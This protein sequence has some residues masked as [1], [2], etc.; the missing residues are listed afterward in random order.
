LGQEAV[1]DTK[2]GV[3]GAGAMGGGIA[4][5]AIRAGFETV[6][7]DVAE[8]A[9]ADARDRIQR[10]L[11]RAA[12][13]SAERQAPALD[14]ST[15]MARLLTTATRLRE[16]A[17]CAVVIEAAPED[18]AIKA[19]LL[20]ELAEVAPSA[21]LASNTSSIEISQLA[22]RSG[23]S[24]RL[25]GLHFFNP[26]ESMRLV[27]HVSTGQ[28]SQE[29]KQRA[30]DLVE[31]FG[32]HVIAVRDSP[33]FLVNRCAR[34]YYLESLRIVED[35]VASPAEVDRACV[36]EGGFP[37]GPFELMDMIGIDVSLAVTR[38]MYEQS[39]G[40]PRWRP[41]GIQRSMVAA[42]RL[43]RKA[44][45]GFYD[46]GHGW[47]EAP[48]VEASVGRM[49]LERLVSQLVNEAAF[50]AADGVAAPDDIDKAMVIGLNHPCG[51]GEWAR[52]LG[53]DRVVQL[54]DDLWA[55]EHDP[56]YRVA[57]ALR[58]RALASGAA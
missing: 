22:R 34:P 20:A 6:L 36:E 50:A 41:S 58:R 19:G 40:E 33:G 37:L 48:G 15:S 16:L 27:E 45:G 44:G 30:W 3:V 8:P 10:S 25:V 29:H 13:R 18:L 35:G 26:P 52:R 28:V 47:R 11:D 56:R 54:L 5:L 9:L 23:T 31:A 49:L 46:E 39:D 4:A 43:G 42:G 24:A 57:P 7:Y 53:V 38:A 2:V 1:T 17:E 32:K 12:E 55:Q 14:G 51:P 21:T